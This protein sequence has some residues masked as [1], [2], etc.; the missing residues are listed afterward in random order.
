MNGNA[1]RLPPRKVNWLLGIRIGNNDL[2]RSP[3]TWT[4]GDVGRISMTF[5]VSFRKQKMQVK[6]ETPLPGSPAVNP[7]LVRYS[8]LVNNWLLQGLLTTRLTQI[9]RSTARELEFL[10]AVVLG[11]SVEWSTIVEFWREKIG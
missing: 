8:Q 10:S 2:G 4:L 3:T 9:Y 5:D 7:E 6:S 1:R 11:R